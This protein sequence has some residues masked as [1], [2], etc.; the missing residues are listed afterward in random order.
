MP[1]RGS[2]RCQTEKAAF[3][4]PTLE[5]PF[6]PIQSNPFGHTFCILTDVEDLEAFKIKEIGNDGITSSCGTIFSLELILK[7]SVPLINFGLT[8]RRRQLRS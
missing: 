1:K 8:K 6:N 4:F 2:A 3:L 5:S 7:S